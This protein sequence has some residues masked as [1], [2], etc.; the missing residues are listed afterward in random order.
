[1]DL[2]DQV[3]A[4]FESEN[5]PQPTEDTA[6]SAGNQGKETPANI[7]IAS[8]NYETKPE[9]KTVGDALDQRIQTIENELRTR[10]ALAVQYAQGG[11]IDDA[12]NL[13]WRA[14]ARNL[15][16]I[17]HKLLARKKKYTAK[18]LASNAVIAEQYARSWHDIQ[19][20]KA[21]GEWPPKRRYKPQPITE[22]A[23]QPVIKTAEAAPAP[24]KAEASE[25]LFDSVSADM[26][27]DAAPAPAKAEASEDLFDS[28]S[29]DMAAGEAPA[30]ESG[31]AEPDLFDSVSA[32]MAASEAPTAEASTAEPDLFDSVS[33]DMAAS[34]GSEESSAEPDLFD[35]VSAEMEE[36]QE[37]DKDEKDTDKE[38]S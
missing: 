21:N 12:Y 5:P 20:L 33:A 35:S 11:K 7:R 4:Q 31:A 23:P 15:F 29:A 9:P 24:A 1:M 16:R 28:V 30:A 18:T 19:R 32:D 25:D 10:E 13:S 6:E 26:A 34:E 17:L 38:A 2:F 22:A 27:G 3:S 37:S 14:E 36:N 8:N